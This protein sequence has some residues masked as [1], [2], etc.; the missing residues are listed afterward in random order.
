MIAVVLGVCLSVTTW[1]VPSPW[2]GVVAYAAGA[3]FCLAIVDVIVTT[4][5][6]WHK[7]RAERHRQRAERLQQRQKRADRSDAPWYR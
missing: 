1:A 6:E 5:L 3:A 2:V 7:G 4:S